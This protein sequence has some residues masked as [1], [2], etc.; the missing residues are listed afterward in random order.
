VAGAKELTP[1]RLGERYAELFFAALAH[2]ATRRGHVN[3]LRHMAGF[4]KKSLPAQEKADL[5]E[6]IDDYHRGY[7]PLIA[8]IT[9]IR[10]FLRRHDVPWLRDQVYLHPHPRELALR[11]HV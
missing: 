3:V 4:F 7:T 8:P 11:N 1:A 10:H 5:Q 6:L 2:R 9:L